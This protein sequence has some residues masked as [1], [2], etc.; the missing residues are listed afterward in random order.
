MIL[1]IIFVGPNL[2]H[3][4]N[5]HDHI[6]DKSDRKNAV[7]KNVN[8]IVFNS[9]IYMQWWNL[10]CARKI[11]DELNIW[12]GISSPIFIAV[13]IG[14]GGFQ[15]VVSTRSEPCTLRERGGFCNA[16]V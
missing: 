11:D 15:A 9:F 2:D 5:K 3:I 16:M 4:K 1:I 6:V 8:S 14:T 13:S 12:Q 10:F 7:Y